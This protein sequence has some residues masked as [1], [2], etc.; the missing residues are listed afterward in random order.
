MN[1]LWS[2]LFLSLLSVLTTVVHSDQSVIPSGVGICN[3]LRTAS[4]LGNT[5]TL[6]NDGILARAVSPANDG[7][8]PPMVQVIGFQLVCEVAGARRDTV[9][10]VSVVVNYMCMGPLCREDIGASD[11]ITLTEQFNFECTSNDA[12]QNL[13]ARESVLVAA[14]F[15]ARDKNPLANLNTPLEDQCSQCVN[16]SVS[17]SANE[18]THCRGKLQL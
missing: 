8:N 18:V 2:A 10:G 6:S 15:A 7:A 9:G 3:K 12:S 5:A 16:P 4:D 14:G 13:T 17:A 1:L 11:V